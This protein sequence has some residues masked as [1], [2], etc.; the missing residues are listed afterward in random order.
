MK[1]AV[2]ERKSLE[3]YHKRIFL[4]WGGALGM[5]E[6]VSLEIPLNV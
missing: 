2:K 3:S 4:V 6:M 1:R 5:V